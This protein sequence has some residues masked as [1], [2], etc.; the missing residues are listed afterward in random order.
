MMIFAFVFIVKK[1]PYDTKNPSFWQICPSPFDLVIVFSPPLLTNIIMKMMRQLYLL[2]FMAGFCVT[3]TQAQQQVVATS[4]NAVQN[5]SGSISWTLGE[6]VVATLT[7]SNDV[8]NQGFQQSALS[9]MTEIH[10]N[11][12]IKVSVWPNPTTEWV[13][14]SLENPENIRYQLYDL[15]GKLLA[16]ENVIDK[17]T[18]IDFSSFAAG[19]YLIKLIQAEKELETISIIKQ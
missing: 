1:L 8:L 9:V 18:E 13:K 10:N 12:V 15:Q 3:T 19:T 4:G 14:I 2:V 11:P 5:S 17:I 6:P 7:T 16:S